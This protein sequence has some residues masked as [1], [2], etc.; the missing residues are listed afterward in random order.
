[1]L[2]GEGEGIVLEPAQ[3]LIRPIVEAAENDLGAVKIAAR[4]LRKMGV[5]EG[6]KFSLTSQESQ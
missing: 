4:V 2:A 3:H 5:F 6:L 1:V